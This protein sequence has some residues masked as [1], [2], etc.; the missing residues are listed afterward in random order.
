M[1]NYHRKRCSA[2]LLIRQIQMKSTMSHLLAFTKIPIIK[3]TDDNNWQECK[4]IRT[5]LPC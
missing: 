4:E 3:I 2:S 1:D 5:L